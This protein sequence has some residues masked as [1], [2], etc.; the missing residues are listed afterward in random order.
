MASLPFALPKTERL[1]LVIFGPKQLQLSGFQSSYDL[2]LQCEGIHRTGINLYP[3]KLTVRSW[4][5]YPKSELL[6]LGGEPAHG[7]AGVIQPENSSF[8]MD[9][10]SFNIPKPASFPLKMV[11][12]DDPASFWDGWP[13]LEADC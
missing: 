7:E 12:S 6:S 8:H 3:W 9:R 4:K 5:L 11:G 2:N 10:H 13:V 1:E